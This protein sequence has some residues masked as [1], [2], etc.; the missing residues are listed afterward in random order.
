M[1]SPTD[2]ERMT[3][4]MVVVIAVLVSFCAVMLAYMSEVLDRLDKHMRRDKKQ[5]SEEASGGL[6][7][8]QHPRP[9]SE[10]Q[11]DERE[12]SPGRHRA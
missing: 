11:G 4:F 3:F 12:S 5:A 6:G 8:P 7:P 1:D 10:Q 2:Y 9:S